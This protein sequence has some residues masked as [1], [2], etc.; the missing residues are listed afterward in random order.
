M[1]LKTHTNYA[2]QYSN[3]SDWQYLRGKSLLNN[4]ANL[5]VGET[6][7]DLGCGTGRLTFLIAEKVTNLGKVIAVDTDI[8]RLN[9]AKSTTPSHINNITFIESSAE[10]LYRISNQSIDLVYSNYVA[11]WIANKSVMTDEIVRCLRPNGYF[12]LELVGEL[13]PFLHYVTSLIG[14]TGQELIDK[15]YCLSQSEWIKHFEQKRLVI[16]RADWLN[17]DFEFNNLDAF[18]DWWEGTTHG[19]FQRSLLSEDSINNLNKQ[20][21]TEVYFSGR[22]FQGVIRKP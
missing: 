7:L 17:L 18:F 8:E 15:F 2:E 1:K 12:V 19:I 6:V 10:D 21:P 3:K 4:V 16:E 5:K 11:H 9:I 13:M 20:F 22:A 14:K